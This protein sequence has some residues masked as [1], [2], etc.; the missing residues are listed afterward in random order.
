MDFQDQEHHYFLNLREAVGPVTR[1]GGCLQLSHVQN[2][3]ALHDVSLNPKLIA[4]VSLQKSPNKNSMMCGF[5][6]FRDYD[7]GVTLFEHPGDSG[8][9]FFLSKSTG[10]FQSTTSTCGW[11]PGLRVDVNF[12]HSYDPDTNTW[13]PWLGRRRG[14]VKAGTSGCF[15]GFLIKNHGKQ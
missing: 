10:N 11:A 8:P 2:E 12:T 1:E 6:F 3:D 14:V 4:V 13:V 15:N 9:P 5:I 7:Y